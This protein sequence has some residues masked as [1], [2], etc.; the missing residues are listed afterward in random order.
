[1]H[2]RGQG[3]LDDATPESDCHSVRFIGWCLPEGT[4][5][6]RGPPPGRSFSIQREATPPLV[7]IDYSGFLPARL[8]ECGFTILFVVFGAR[9]WFVRAFAHARLFV[10]LIMG[11]EAIIRGEKLLI[12]FCISAFLYCTQHKVIIHECKLY[13]KTVKWS[14]I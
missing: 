5:E 10:E 1:M 13:G 7:G 3:L 2:P 9:L 12:L 14:M 8:E 4:S 6:V 11:S